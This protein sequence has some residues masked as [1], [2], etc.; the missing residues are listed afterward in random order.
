MNLYLAMA[1]RD[2]LQAHRSLPASREC[3][4][5]PKIAWLIEEEIREGRRVREFMCPNG[6]LHISDE[7]LE[8]PERP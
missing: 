4:V 3:E 8:P 6:H 7:A 5:C 1:V 2:L